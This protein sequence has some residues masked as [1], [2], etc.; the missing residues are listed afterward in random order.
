MNQASVSEWHKRF[1]EGRDSVRDD[2][3]CGGDLRSTV[4]TQRPK[5]KVPSGSILTLLDPRRPDRASLPT[6]F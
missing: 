3:R 4:M 2:E 1:K 6:N 5:D